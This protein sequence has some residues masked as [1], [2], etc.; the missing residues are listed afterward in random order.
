MDSCGERA[1]F[2][3]LLGA[4]KDCMMKNNRLHRISGNHLKCGEPTRHAYFLLLLQDSFALLLASLFCLDLLHGYVSM[5]S[6]PKLQSE[7]SWSTEMVA[8]CAGKQHAARRV[9][10]ARG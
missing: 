2:F 8:L 4:G 7:K 5:C 3:C 1:Q 9:Q 10:E 6:R